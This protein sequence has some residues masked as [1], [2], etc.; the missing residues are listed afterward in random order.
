MD[1]EVD[2]RVPYIESYI[3]VGRRKPRH[4]AF[5]SKLPVRV[6]RVD[7]ADLRPA[8]RIVPPK[9]RPRFRPYV[10]QS[11]KNSLWWP[12]VVDGVAMTPADFR[13]RATKGDMAIVAMLGVGEV[14]HAYKSRD[15]FYAEFPATKIVADTRDQQWA[16]AQRGAAER[17]LFCGDQV[18]LDAGEPI[19]YLGSYADFVGP[20]FSKRHT[21]L[22]SRGDNR[23]WIAHRGA[24][25][26]IEEIEKMIA[27]CA[28]PPDFERAS[29]RI[30]SLVERHR[31]DGAA[32]ACA[33]ALIRHLVWK[34]LLPSVHGAR[35]RQRFAH[36]FSELGDQEGIDEGLCRRILIEMTSA[37]PREARKDLNWEVEVAGNVLKRLERLSP[38]ALDEK[39]DEALG[40][41]GF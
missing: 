30:E 5:W 3:P 18:L 24:A 25:Y 33:R 38:P 6:L 17:I 37:V 26:G 2:L 34:A 14:R 40:A 7:D 8:Y 20:S 27:D 10:V 4:I 39:D 16:R 13:S 12:I 15:S 35:L 29:G 41:L 31:I 9:R 1:E 36:L 23:E 21:D 22:P 19:Y 32:L 11:F 28:V